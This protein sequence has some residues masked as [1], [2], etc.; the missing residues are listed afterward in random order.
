MNTLFN[1]IFSVLITELSREDIKKKKISTIA[2]LAG[3]VILLSLEFLGRMKPEVFPAAAISILK[4]IPAALFAFLFFTACKKVSEACYSSTLGN[5]DIYFAVFL[6][7]W[8]NIPKQIVHCLL[9]AVLAAVYVFLRA[10][11]SSN[12]NQKRSARPLPFI[13]FMS[14]AFLLLYFPV[15][16]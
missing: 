2:L 7:L 12:L 5:G 15:Q 3:T 8:L 10:F 4:K 13:P 11:I 9:S 16:F 6:A 1:F 14:L